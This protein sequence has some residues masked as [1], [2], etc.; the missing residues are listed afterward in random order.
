MF[1]KPYEIDGTIVFP[2][3][4]RDLKKCNGILPISISESGDIIYKI[5]GIF[6]VYKNAEEKKPFKTDLF[7]DVEYEDVGGVF[8]AMVEAMFQVSE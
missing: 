5:V 1:K 4:Q 3:S 7:D 8:K 2:D 6:D